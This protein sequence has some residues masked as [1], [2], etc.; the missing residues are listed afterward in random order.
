MLIWL[1]VCYKYNCV[2]RKN[3][4]YIYIVWKEREI[5]INLKWYETVLVSLTKF[6]TALYLYLSLHIA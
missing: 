5:E 3:Q 4:H 6:I 1:T 2:Y